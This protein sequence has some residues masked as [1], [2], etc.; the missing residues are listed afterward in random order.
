MPDRKDVSKTSHDDGDKVPAQFQNHRM[1]TIQARGFVGVELIQNLVNFP[2][3]AMQK[4][5]I[6]VF[7][8]FG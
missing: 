2:R 3:Q 7:D 6:S 1:N 4:T 8:T 5:E